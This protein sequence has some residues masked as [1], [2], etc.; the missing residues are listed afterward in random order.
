MEITVKLLI[1]L[2]A[3]TK[4]SAIFFHKKSFAK[5]VLNRMTQGRRARQKYFLQKSLFFMKLFC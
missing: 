2:Y 5:C 3:A 1:N 4:N